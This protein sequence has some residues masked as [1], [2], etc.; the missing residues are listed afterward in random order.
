MAMLND[1]WDMLFDTYVPR[2]GEPESR[3]VR[4]HVYK[5][6]N[7]DSVRIRI[8]LMLPDRRAGTTVGAVIDYKVANSSENLM[9]KRNLLEQL[10][11]QVVLQLAELSLEEG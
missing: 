7:S 11:E 4:W 10:H 1:N 5:P 6:V 8:E 3:P 9:T 2:A